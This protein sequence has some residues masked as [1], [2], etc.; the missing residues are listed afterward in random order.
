VVRITVDTRN[1]QWRPALT[2]MTMVGPTVT[3]VTGD[4]K[5]SQFAK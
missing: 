1:I 4:F 5:L 3:I 2:H